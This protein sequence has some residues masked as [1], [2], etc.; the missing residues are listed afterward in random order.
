MDKSSTQSSKIYRPVMA[1]IAAFSLASNVL[2]FVQFTSQ[3]ISTGC[4]IYSS[5]NGASER[6]IELE[7]V[8]ETLGAFMSSLETQGTTRTI[9]ETQAGIF[10]PAQTTENLSHIRALNDLAK[11]CAQLCHELLE[12]IQKLKVQGGRWRPFK[13]FKAA[14]EASWD[15]KKVANLEA[16]L[17]R[18]QRVTLFHFFPILRYFSECMDLKMIMLIICVLGISNVPRCKW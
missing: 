5:A 12:T 14:L 8:Y 18:F 3:L 7:R 10:I 4:E 13:S 17:D 2:Q 15:S 11:E 6:N 9:S 16:R 1:S